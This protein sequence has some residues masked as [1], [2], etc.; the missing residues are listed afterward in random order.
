MKKMLPALTALRFFAAFAI[1]I[2]HAGGYFGIPKNSPFVFWGTQPVSF[3]FVLSG[4]ILFYSYPT[5]PGKG[6]RWRFFLARFARI[7][8]L[9]ALTLFF[10]LLLSFY[11]RSEFL[12]NQFNMDAVG[13]FF[14]NI[15]LL[16]AWFPFSIVYASFNQVAWSISAEFAFYFMF[17]LVL[18]GW[19]IRW[20]WWLLGSFSIVLLAIFLCSYFQIPRFTEDYYL[21]NTSGIFHVNPAVRF[22]EFILGVCT[23][24]YFRR[25]QN[26]SGNGMEIFAL[27]LFLG[28]L[29][30]CSWLKNILGGFGGEGLRAWIAHSGSCFSACFLIYVFARGEGI[31]SRIFS[32]RPLFILGESSFSLYLLHQMYFSAF[33]TRSHPLVDLPIFLQAPI[34]VSGVLLASYLCWRYFE[35]PA[36]NWILKRF[37]AKNT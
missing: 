16:Q 22:F 18:I 36:K 23:G 3:F 34:Y 10:A 19:E 15:S 32:W 20:K 24:S 5:L 6:D 35:L 37:S 8:P 12:P 29:L 11:P 30:F 28:N 7:W 9:H 21:L 33:R 1:L 2:Y 31:F 4:F 17:P 13:I 27:L 25:T 14:L 26:K